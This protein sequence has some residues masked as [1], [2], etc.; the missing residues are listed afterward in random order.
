MTLPGPDLQLSIFT[1]LSEA[2]P[3]WQQLKA[4]LCDIPYQSPDWLE[5]WLDTLGRQLEVSP[6]IAVGRVDGRAVVL[7]PL[8]LEKSLGVTTLSFLG[9]QHGN[10]NTGV[11]DPDFYARANPEQILDFL[12]RIGL[13]S[14]ADLLKL[15]NVPQAWCGR[16]HPLVLTSAT[17]SPS[18]VFRRPLPPDFEE[19]FRQGHSKSARKNLLRKERNLGSAGNFRVSKATTPAEISRGLAAFLEQRA[20][21]AAEAGIPNVFD[22][23]AG[24]AFLAR[25]LGLDP[26]DAPSKPAL[27]SL[28]VLEAGGALRATYLCIDHGGTRYAYTNSIAHDDMLQNSP[29]LVLIKE[30]IAQ[31]CADPDLRHLDLGLGEERYKTA[32]ANPVPL[33]DSRMAFSPKGSLTLRADRLRRQAKSAVRNSAWLWPLVRRLRKWKAGLANR[34]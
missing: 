19:A 21:R 8:A 22:Q 5:A 7:L 6:L 9:H 34:S 20:R 17:P 2:R 11:W 26:G 33:S 28:W 27:M 32:W 3:D 31:A 23:E 12:R 10:Q 25:L 24:R 16:A 30:I 14:G 15:E 1:R 13:Q 4:A 29:G 18:L